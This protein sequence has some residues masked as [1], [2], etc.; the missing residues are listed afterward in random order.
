MKQ[1]KAN[2]S[3]A[4]GKDSRELL[5]NP[6]G[7]Y[8]PDLRR[9]FLHGGPRRGFNGISQAG[10]ESN[11][12]KQTELVLAEALLRI[13]DRANNPVLDIVLSGNVVDDALLHRI[14]QQAIDGEI[15]A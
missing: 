3:A 8:L 4:F 10:A 14:V 12:P 1:S 6:L 7:A 2:G 9:H 15:S 5:A 11:R 13:A